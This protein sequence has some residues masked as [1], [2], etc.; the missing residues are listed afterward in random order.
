M[1]YVLQDMS[2]FF[3]FSHKLK[4]IFT[5]LQFNLHTYQ[6]HFFGGVINGLT[7]IYLNSTQQHISVYI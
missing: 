3:S 7:Q 2:Y 1:A 5:S 6:L 4:T